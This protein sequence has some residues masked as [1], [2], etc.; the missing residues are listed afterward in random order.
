MEN[1]T[2]E[3]QNNIEVFYKHNKNTPRVALCFNL[4]L[5]DTAKTPGIYSLMS[6]LL[7]QGTKTR[8]AEELA[9]ELE[10][11]A[12][13]CSAELKTDYLSFRLLCLNE[14]FSKAVELLTD[15]IKNSTFDE[16]DKELEKMKG[17]IIAQLDSPRLK[18]SD[19]YYKNIFK[20]HPY[21]VTHT[22][23]LENI[24]KLKKQDVI[25]AYNNIISNSKKVI[26]IVGELPY[27]ETIK[28]LDESFGNIP[29]D[30]DVKNIPPV[31]ALDK[32][33]D[34]EILK[35]DV[36]QAHILKGWIVNSYTD[37]DYAA[38]TLLNIIL[39]ASG[40]S[41]RLFLELRDK[42]GLA[43][44][45][46]SSYE[47][48]YLCGNFS[49]YIATEPKNIEVS[50]AGFKEEIAKI[51][52][53]KISE[54]ELENAKNNII[55][56]WAFIQETNSQQACRYAHYGVLGLGFDFM[57]KAKDLIKQVTVE[58]IQ[59]CANKYFTDNYTSAVL[60]P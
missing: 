15:I 35:P 41:S 36:N 34:V 10:E 20:N 3:L 54:E 22:T 49:I 5:N 42:K 24:D 51:K 47:P 50:M 30:K 23:I 11:Y 52:T 55:G 1:N 6:R 44:V 39:G 8:S 27:D 17:E 60:K 25:D 16:F 45:V 19:A 33:Q 4:S 29:N 46:R 18:A 9:N 32:A 28:M 43:Y 7:M 26:T 40:L 59:E 58:Q 14:D 31:T 48:S 53:I 2:V 21:G 57:Q 56:R 37:K 38:L 12:I 13:E